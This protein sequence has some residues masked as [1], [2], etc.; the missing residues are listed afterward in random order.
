M[1]RGW[2]GDARGSHSGTGVIL[3]NEMLNLG[4]EA[5]AGIAQSS[6]KYGQ[7]LDAPHKWLTVVGIGEDGLAGISD[8]ARSQVLSAE[9]LMGGHRHLSMVPNSDHQRQIPWTSPLEQTLTT[10]NQYRGQAV[11]VLASGDP[12]CYGIGVSLLRFVPLAEMTILP[13]PS[14]FSWA[15]ARLGWALAD[16]ETISL[17]G[18]DPHYLNVLLYPHARILLLSADQRT[19]AQVADL[20]TQQGYGQSL[21]QVWEHLGGQQERRIVLKAEDGIHEAIAPLNLMAIECS[22]LAAGFPPLRSQRAGLPDDAFLHDG[23]ITKQEVRAVTLAALSPAP[24]E[25]LWDVGAGCGSISVEWLRTHRRCAA[26]AIESNPT[27][28]QYL[29]E[30]AL[31]LGTPSLKLV[32]GEA[33]TV[34]PGLPQPDAIFIGGGLT[35]PNLLDRCWQAL[36]PGGRLVANAVTVK[37]EGL[38]YQYQDR[39]GGKL[40]RI[41]IQRAA[42]MGTVMAWHALAP[43]TQWVVHKP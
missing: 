32:A 40:T 12:M 43:V 21:I 22:S 3:A 11:C 31:R 41:A 6:T 25:L 14:A 37:S 42:T 1:I 9:I 4:W 19:P 5:T 18:R 10:L 2:N 34:L 28:Q 24:G 35:T 17:C 8:L 20:L 38:I 39:W 27:R 13:A 36:K 26:I 16:V 15:A 30:N 33:P 7:F 29:Q 23:Q